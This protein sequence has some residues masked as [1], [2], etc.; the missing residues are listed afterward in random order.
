MRRISNERNSRSD[1]GF[2]MRVGER[3]GCGGSRLHGEDHRWD[4]I[5]VV[6]WDSS[7]GRRVKEGEMRMR[8]NGSGGVF[9]QG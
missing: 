7:W 9:D 2:S 6:R 1:V 4:E 8:L 5:V 3:E